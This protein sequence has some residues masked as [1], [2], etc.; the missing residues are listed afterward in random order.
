MFVPF[1]SRLAQARDPGIGFHKHEDPVSP[2]SVRAARSGNPHDAGT[3]SGDLHDFCSCR[4]GTKKRSNTSNPRAPVN[5]SPAA[6]QKGAR[7]LKSGSSGFKIP[8]VRKAKS[9]PAVPAT[10]MARPMAVDRKSSG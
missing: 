7:E 9:V 4:M 6:N 5:P 2:W 10:L 1:G 8:L 3:D